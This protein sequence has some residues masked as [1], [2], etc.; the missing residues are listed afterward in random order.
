MV[1]FSLSMRILI[2]DHFPVT[3]IDSLDI[4]KARQSF[5]SIC[6]ALESLLV[7]VH[8]QVEG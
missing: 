3:D 4:T 8:S 1:S 2:G 6:P 5:S 7:T